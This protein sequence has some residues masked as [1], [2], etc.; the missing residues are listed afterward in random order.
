MTATPRIYGDAANDKAEEMKAEV[1][2]M[3]DIS[4]YGEVFYSCK[5]IKSSE[6]FTDEFTKVYREYL[7]NNPPQNI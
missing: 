4:K 5:S 6:Q 2:S 3:D 7:S 1:Y